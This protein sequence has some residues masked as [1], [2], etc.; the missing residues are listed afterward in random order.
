M[1][2]MKI[3]IDLDGTVFETYDTLEEKFVQKF[4]RKMNW[5]ALKSGKNH[6][7]QTDGGKWIVKQ[8]KDPNFY[9]NLETYPDAPKVLRQLARKHTIIYCTARRFGLENATSYSLGYRKLP[10][11]KVY[12]IGRRHIAGVKKRIALDEKIDLAIDDESKVVEKLSEVCQ[13]LIFTQNYNKGCKFGKRVK[14]WK[15]VRHELQA[16][17][18]NNRTS[19]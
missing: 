2:L 7:W 16:K 19:K 12:C 18:R 13:V 15:E 3:L 17:K 5:Q 4:N 11:G 14:S 10:F 1:I 6:Y 9:Y 8:F